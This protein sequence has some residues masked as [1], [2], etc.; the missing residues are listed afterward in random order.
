MRSRPASSTLY[1]YECST[2]VMGTRATARVDTPIEEQ[3]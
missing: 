1:G 3:E 2:G